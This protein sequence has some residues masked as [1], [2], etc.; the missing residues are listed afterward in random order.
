MQVTLL[1]ATFFAFLALAAPMATLA[2]QIS[3]PTN[4]TTGFDATIICTDDTNGASG[5]LTFF[6]VRNGT[7]DTLAENPSSGGN[8]TVMIPANAT[9][10]GWTIQATSS[11]GEVVGTSSPFAILAPPKTGRKSMAIPIIGAVF[12]SLIVFSLLVLALFL[13]IRRRR[14]QM[15]AAG[16]EFNLEASFPPRNGSNQFSRSSTSTALSD[17]N[18]KSSK[19]LET[20]KVEWEMQLE[21]Q[22]ARAR[23][24]TPDIRGGTPV[25]RMMTPRAPP[26]PPGP[27]AQPELLVSI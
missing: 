11:N 15:F 10:D 3:V 4:I 21:E 24:A 16:P 1:F 23:A 22:F 19:S 7:R 2:M 8:L 9:G 5:P 12:G 20:E 6:L 25:S 13:Y 17:T 18:V 14:R 27:H 26:A